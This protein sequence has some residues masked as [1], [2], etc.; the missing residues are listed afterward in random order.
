[1]RKGQP[2]CL[3]ALPGCWTQ[4]CIDSRSVRHTIG[5]LEVER[6]SRSCRPAL[7]RQ[8]AG[9]ICGG[10]NGSVTGCASHASLRITHLGGFRIDGLMLASDS[11]YKLAVK[12]DLAVQLGDCTL[13]FE[14]RGHCDECVAAMV[15]G[16]RIGRDAHGLTAQ[17]WVSR[18][19]RSMR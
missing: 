7:P 12:H 4:L 10:W 1:M 16:A 3:R 17:H 19:I 9:V 5:E 14:R 18:L 6:N 13:G 2:V 15:V 11:H 8:C